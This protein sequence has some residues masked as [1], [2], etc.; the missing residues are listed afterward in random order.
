MVFRA[1]SPSG[2]SRYHSKLEHVSGCQEVHIAGAGPAGLAFALR[3]AE[4]IENKQVN[5]THGRRA[6]IYVWD[7]RLHRVGL[8]R[9]RLE[10]SRRVNDISF[11]VRRQTVSSD[12]HYTKPSPQS[13]SA[14]KGK[15]ISQSL[16]FALLAGCQFAALNFE[17]NLVL[18][19]SGC[20][21]SGEQGTPL[22]GNNQHLSL[23]GGR[24]LIEARTVP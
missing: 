20:N 13:P 10:I 12:D 4:N 19:H 11:E 3:L 24:C 8:R 9:R 14:S 22:G 5:V 21:V 1:Q 15:M 2:G 18:R 23:K 6:V 17:C 7:A 16:R